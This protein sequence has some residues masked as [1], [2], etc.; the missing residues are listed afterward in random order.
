ENATS[1][2][3]FADFTL[4]TR[5]PTVG[6]VYI[7]P[8]KGNHDEFGN[9]ENENQTTSLIS[10][11]NGQAFRLDVAKGQVNKSRVAVATGLTERKLNLS[12]LAHVEGDAFSHENFANDNE[13]DKINCFVKIFIVPRN[14]NSLYISQHFDKQ[15]GVY[16][17]N[18]TNA[19]EISDF[20]WGDWKQ[21][22]PAW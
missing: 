14:I 11:G 19:L 16:K 13:R 22:N 15:S 17:L 10:L 7:M 3:V 9:I 5:E 21:F 1:Y 20:T 8:E 4:E 18:Y 2:D 12:T 6:G